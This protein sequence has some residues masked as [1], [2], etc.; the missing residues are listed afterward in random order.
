M[1]GN[2]LKERIMK[3]KERVDGVET[4]LLGQIA[5]LSLLESRWNEID[6]YAEQVRTGE[7]HLV[8]F[9]VCGK[10]FQT[11]I[12]TLVNIKDT[13]FYKL[14]VSRKVDLKKP[15]FLTRSPEWFSI[16]F[17]YLRKKSLDIKRFSKKQLNELRFEAEY[18]ELNDILTE[19]GDSYLD[20]EFVR[21]E[22]SGAYFANNAIVG[23]NTLDDLG[24]RN[25]A[26]GGIIAASPGKILIELNKVW[27][28]DSLEIGGYSGNPSY[29]SCD[30]GYGATIELSED[31]KT[32][33]NIGTIPYGYGSNIQRVSFSKQKALYI[34]FT[35]SSYIGIGFLKLHQAK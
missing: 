21:L 26:K 1:D 28:V 29:W 19:M 31:N 27:E 32:W 15:I 23:A 11:Y 4:V 10:R 6:S 33:S 25:L 30:N 14:V 5:D 12:A 16:I 2:A 8:T 20:V 13:F 22:T 7:Q 24:D 3:L 35:Y 18:Y 17:D 34:K 9:N